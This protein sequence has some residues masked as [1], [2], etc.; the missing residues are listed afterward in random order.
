[1]VTNNFIPSSR[2]DCWVRLNHCE[3]YLNR[4]AKTADTSTQE[5]LRYILQ[6]TTQAMLRHPDYCVSCYSSVDVKSNV[7]EAEKLFK[8]ISVEERGKFGDQT[9]VNVNNIRKEIATSQLPNEYI[10]VS[11]TDMI[12]I[13]M[14]LSILCVVY[15]STF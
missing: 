10:G 9:L 6:G 8:N 2:L 5:S 14:V 15:G 12:A 1:M 7:K 13:H 3:K 4:I 11:T